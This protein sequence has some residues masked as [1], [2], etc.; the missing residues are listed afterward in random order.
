MGNSF[1]LFFLA[2]TFSPGDKVVIAVDLETAKKLQDGHGGWN[3]S[4][5]DVGL[6]VNYL[7]HVILTFVFTIPV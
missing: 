3:D 5:G 2:E 7:F 4:M 6:D 1:N